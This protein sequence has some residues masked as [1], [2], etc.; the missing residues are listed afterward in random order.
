MGVFAAEVLAGLSAGQRR[1][2]RSAASGRAA[3]FASRLAE[4]AYVNPALA[5]PGAQMVR[6]DG[7]VARR[8]GAP[9]R[10]FSLLTRP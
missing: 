6:L 4:A 8:P 9:R 1:R 7:A 2:G 10:E 3:A 5:S